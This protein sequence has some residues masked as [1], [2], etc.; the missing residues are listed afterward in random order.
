MNK[1]DEIGKWGRREVGG[2]RCPPPLHNYVRANPID[3]RILFSV[4]RRRRWVSYL[5][6]LYELLALFDDDWSDARPSTS[7]SRSPLPSGCDAR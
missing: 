1:S 3:L 6:L 4:G 5:R 7:S 2:G